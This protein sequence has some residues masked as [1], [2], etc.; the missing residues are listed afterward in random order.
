MRRARTP[1]FQNRGSDAKIAKITVGNDT[2]R[3]KGRSGAALIG[4]EIDKRVIGSGRL[5]FSTSPFDRT[6]FGRLIVAVQD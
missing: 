1:T 5:T 2:P 3:V 4:Q 6:C